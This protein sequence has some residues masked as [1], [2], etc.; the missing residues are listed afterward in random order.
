MRAFSAIC[1][2]TFIRGFRA[3]MGSW[4]IMAMFRPRYWFHCS[5]LRPRKSEPSK[6]IFP[7]GIL[8]FRGCRPMAERAVMVLPQPDSPTR[9]N[10]SPLR[11]WKLTSSTACT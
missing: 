1:R 9:P 3:V 10:A 4:K 5:S 11:I 7:W 6:R 8:A 2:P